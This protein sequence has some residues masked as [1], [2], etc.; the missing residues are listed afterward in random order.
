MKNKHFKL[1]VWGWWQ[2]GNLGDNWIKNIMKKAFPFA[3]CIPTSILKFNGFD[4]IIC[5]ISSGFIFP[6][7]TSN[8]VPTII[9]T[10]LYKNP[11]PLIFTI[12][13]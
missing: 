5:G 1:G 3:K 6:V 7:P 10:M 4:F 2:G 9:L 8:N 13:I 12:A 11:S